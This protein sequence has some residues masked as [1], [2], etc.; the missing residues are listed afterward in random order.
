MRAK[1]GMRRG[2][3]LMTSARRSEDAP[4]LRIVG[5]NGG[6]LRIVG[7]RAEKLGCTIITVLLERGEFVPAEQHQ[8]QPTARVKRADRDQQNQHQHAYQKR[9]SPGSVLYFQRELWLCKGKRPLYFLRR[10]KAM[11]RDGEQSG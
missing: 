5:R 9:P 10:R 4:L 1:E 8:R 7:N 11:A 3:N 6:R 2:R